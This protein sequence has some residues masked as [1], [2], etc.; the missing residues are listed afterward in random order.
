MKLLATLLCSLALAS[1]GG[2]F[3]STQ[4]SAPES[5]PSMKLG[6]FSVSLAV[7]DIAAS[8]AFYEQLGFSEAGGNQAQNWLILRSG[9][10][11]IGLFQGMFEDNIM[12]F[13][14][15]WNHNAEELDEFTDIREIQARL[16]AQGVELLTEADA[17][18]TGPA[19]FTLLDPDGNMILVDQHVK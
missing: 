5:V 6:A 17:D 2:L 7:K 18:S 3:S 11:T 12:T 14:P 4:D 9:T 15:G 1:G 10:T 13:N 19:S 8:R 16:K